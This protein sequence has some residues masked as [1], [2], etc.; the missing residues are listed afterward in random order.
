MQEANNEGSDGKRKQ[1]RQV[2]VRRESHEL[3]IGCGGVVE[4]R[5]V[6][7]G[8]R[9]AVESSGQGCHLLAPVVAIERGE[10]EQVFCGLRYADAGHYGLAS[11]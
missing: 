4:A 9:E 10:R 5:D 1:V 6:A 3:L 8:S 2:A 11:F 7:A